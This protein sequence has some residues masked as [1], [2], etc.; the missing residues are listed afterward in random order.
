MRKPASK[1]ITSD[2]VELCETAVCF[3]HIHL[4]G[5]KVRHLKMHEIPPEV[6]L[7]SSRSPGVLKQSQSALFGSVSHIAILPDITRVVNVRRQTS[8]ASVTSSSP[9]RGPS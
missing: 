8:Q 6:D 2:S 7:G 1:H 4:M 5:T 3:L 9:I